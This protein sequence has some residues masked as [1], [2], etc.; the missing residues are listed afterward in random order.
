MSFP[1][2]IK[3]VTSSAL[4]VGAVSVALAASGASASSLPLAERYAARAGAQVAELSLLGRTAVFGSA[5]TDSSLDAVGRVLSATATGTG[6][7]LSPATQSVA[8]FGDSG[9]T[10]GDSCA[11]TPL[12]PAVAA[13]RT[14]LPAADAG[15]LPAID[16]APACGRST[17][18][19]TPEVFNAE[20]TGGATRIRVRL[21]D[22]LKQLVG[23][24]TASLSPE[25]L[26]TPVGDL[27]KQAAPVAGAPSAPTASAVEAGHVV[28]TLN[29]VIGRLAP[30]VALPAM[31]PQQ[32]VGTMLQR[33]QGS[34]LLHIDMATATAR[35]GGD[36]RAYLA[37][38]L[39]DGGTI[40]VLPEFRGAGT[41][42]LLRLTISRSRASVPVDRSSL[43]AVPVVENAVVRVQSELLD[44]GLPSEKAVA[45]LG[46]RSGAGFVEVGPGQSL[47]VLCD[48]A[49][50][51]LCSEVSVGAAKPPATLPNGATRAEASTVTVHLFKGL[52][53]VT[54]GG[55]LGTVL[56]QPAV[57]KALQA[58]APAEAAAGRPTDIPGVRLVSGGVV[59]E[60]G[61]ARV[62]G[63]QAVQAPTSSDDVASPAA[64]V[65][66]LPHTG[67]QPYSPVT[68]PVLLG[69]A[70][71]LARLT[72]RNGV[73]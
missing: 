14:K 21:S 19:G 57:A 39:S 17:V 32:T 23:T 1:L 68:A 54:S 53:G 20:S 5:V 2:K 49:V 51:P 61:G 9:A 69:G 45:A 11:A 24:A 73:A 29:G 72:R 18:S 13:A 67:G 28:A 60:A 12:G 55:T 30:G 40:D 52:D 41:A 44:G 33:L 31:E 66:N 22:A 7:D 37:E 65:K 63:E 46:L 47:P 50:A 26:A 4:A 58:A 59:A 27:V 8:R 48:G 38:A 35:N 71:V 70:A 16:A 36:A 10:G 3:S 64:P 25:T 6:T 62:L 56:A 42:P 15:A 34:D 43:H